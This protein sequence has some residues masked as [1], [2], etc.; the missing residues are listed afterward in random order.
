M[1]KYRRLE[2]PLGCRRHPNPMVEDLRCTYIQINHFIEERLPDILQIPPTRSDLVCLLA[3]FRFP[4]VSRRG[5]RAIFLL[6]ICA[7]VLGL[8][9]SFVFK[10]NFLFLLVFTIFIKI[11]GPGSL[12]F[13][14]L[15][16]LAP[17]TILSIRV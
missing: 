14:T 15:N 2:D 3:P 9:T 13:R 1:W 11:I 12:G 8:T 10:V 16:S 5:S 6:A 7:H 4:R 17:T